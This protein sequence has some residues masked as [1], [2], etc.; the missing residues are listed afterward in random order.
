MGLTGYEWQLAPGDADD[1]AVSEEADFWTAQALAETLAEAPES[2]P[3]ALTE[4]P[5]SS[6]PPTRRLTKKTSEAD[7][8]RIPPRSPP[9][10][11]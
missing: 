2:A 11:Q 8:A 3:E 10:P 7:I 1:L 5:G 4:A 6:S 9:P